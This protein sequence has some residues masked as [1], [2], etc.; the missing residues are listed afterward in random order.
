M[1][2]SEKEIFELAFEFC[3]KNSSI[4]APKQF[5][6]EAYAVFNLMKGEINEIDKEQNKNNTPF[7]I[8]PPK[9]KKV[10]DSF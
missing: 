7:V 8:T 9:K 1:E 6:R 5:I 2:I 3:L 10:Y 4:S